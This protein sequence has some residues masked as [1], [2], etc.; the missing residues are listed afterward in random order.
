MTPILNPGYIVG[1]F[2]ELNLVDAN[3]ISFIEDHVLT[4]KDPP[5]FERPQLFSKYLGLNKAML[6]KLLDQDVSP[7][8][9]R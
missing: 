7:L 2:S 3:L 9:C 6:D 5:V 1:E 4:T 8:A